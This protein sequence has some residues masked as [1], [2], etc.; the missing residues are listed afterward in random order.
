MR[1]DYC[2]CRPTCGC[3]VREWIPPASGISGRDVRINNGNEED[4][5]GSFVDPLLERLVRISNDINL[6][7]DDQRDLINAV[8]LNLP[9]DQTRR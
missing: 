5:R 7:D 1:A 6:N 2:N 9:T 8:L 4:A 3:L